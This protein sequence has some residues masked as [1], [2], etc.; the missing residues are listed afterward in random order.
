MA[1]VQDN[2]ATTLL[3]Q[4]EPPERRNN[5]LMREIQL[6][7]A[8]A[9]VSRWVV[10]PIQTAVQLQQ[11]PH[12]WDRDGSP[13]PSETAVNTAIQIIDNAARVGFDDFPAPH[14]FPVPGGGV[15]LEWRQGERRLEI[16]V[17]PTG[18]AEYLKLQPGLPGEEGEF[19]T[20][21]PTQSKH[22][23]EWL[24]AFE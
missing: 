1:L 9:V 7:I 15:Q 21:P 13:P 4:Y 17:L 22:I 18:E 16:E 12:N 23:F 14:V 20:W 11:L 3:D 24:V 5:D 6:D 10:E 2:A 19:P 8:I